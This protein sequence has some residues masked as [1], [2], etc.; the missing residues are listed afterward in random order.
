[1]D[2]SSI[3]DDLKSKHAALETQ[4]DAEAQRPM[5]DQAKVTEIKREKLRIK[6]QI[7]DLQRD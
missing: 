5:P 3:I 1:M 2:S 4:L 6:D 7:A